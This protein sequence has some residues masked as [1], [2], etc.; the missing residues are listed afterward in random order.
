MS[1]FLLFVGNSFCL[2]VFWCFWSPSPQ[3]GSSVVFTVIGCLQPSQ[4][5]GCGVQRCH[6]SLIFA[7]ERVVAKTRLLRLQPY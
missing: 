5:F 7:E 6:H 1:Q 4:D 2:I 3:A